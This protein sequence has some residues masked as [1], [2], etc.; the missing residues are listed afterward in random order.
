MRITIFLSIVKYIMIFFFFFDFLTRLKGGW[1]RSMTYFIE[2]FTIVE[3]FHPWISS[4]QFLF[5]LKKKRFD[6]IFDDKNQE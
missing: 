6:E 1:S 3:N 2:N 5:L 4:F